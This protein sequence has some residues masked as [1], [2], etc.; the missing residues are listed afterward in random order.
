MASYLRP[1]HGEAPRGRIF[2]TKDGSPLRR[3]TP[4]V[5]MSKKE[6]LKLR[7]IAK[8]SAN[9]REAVKS[10]VVDEVLDGKAKA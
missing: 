9:A 4:K 5:R 10:T 6:R 7:A 1:I 2:Y 3:A 8:A